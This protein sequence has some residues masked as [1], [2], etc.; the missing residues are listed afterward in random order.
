MS[1]PGLIIIGSGP[2]G[3]GAAEAFRTHNRTLPVRLISADP[4]LPYQRPPLSKDFLRG[5]TDD[6]ALH[7]RSWFAERDIELVPGVELDRIEPGDG[8]AVIGGDR[9]SYTALVLATGATPAPLPVAGGERALQLRSLADAVRLRAASSHADSAVV[10]GAGFIGCEAAASLARRGVSVTLVARQGVPQQKRL[11][12]DAGEQLLRLVKD[13]GVHYVGGVSVD[14]IHEGGVVALDS[15]VNIECD[16]VL[17]ATGVIPNS[18]A[19]EAAGLDIEQS[20]VFVGADMAA[21]GSAP[22]IFAAGDVALA[23]NTS[24]GRRIATEH[25]QDAADQ[26]AIAGASA[27]SVEAKWDGV[28]GFWTTIGDS[29]VKYHAWGDGYDSCRLMRREDGFTVWYELDGVTVGVLTL[30]ADDDYELG[31]RLIKDGSPAPVGMR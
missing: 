29:D 23:H 9:Y 26:G 31:E 18:G 19:A 24:A 14:A 5:E 6:V 10:I 4:E 8:M 2:A 30:N 28:P 12:M 7:S 25:W 16:L 3:L 15:G 11:G 17:A 13:A 21:V 1:E 22:N 27:A 20:R